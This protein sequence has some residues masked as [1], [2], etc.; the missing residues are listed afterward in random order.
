MTP[1]RTWVLLALALGCPSRPPVQRTTFDDSDVRYAEEEASMEAERHPASDLVSQGEAELAAG[2][3]R[4]AMALFEQA[5]AQAPNDPRAHLDLGLVLELGNE[6]DEAERA[7]R[8][9]LALDPRFPEVLNNLGLL[10]RDLERPDEAVPLLRL[11]VTEKPGFGEAWLNLAMALEESGDDAGAEEA[12]RRAVR[13]R[14]DDGVARANF[15]LLFLRRGRA[16]QAAIELRRAMPLAR[17]SDW[18]RAVAGRTTGA[19]CS[20]A[21]QCD[22]SAWRANASVAR[23]AGLG[24]ARRW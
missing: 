24:A 15:G 8:A 18:T 1:R 5:L 12:Y 7:Y 23:R 14:P 3:P 9:A 16:E 22:R 10:L 21:S 6:F 19:S 4:Q 2:R 13:L 11:A 17:P 20:G